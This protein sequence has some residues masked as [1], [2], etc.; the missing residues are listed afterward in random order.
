M[1]SD[2]LLWPLAEATERETMPTFSETG[3]SR[4]RPIVLSKLEASASLQFA[5]ALEIDISSPGADHKR[6]VIY[7]IGG[8]TP[9]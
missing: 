5:I 9:G 7:E 4:L 3:N 2:G 6:E 1:S 8:G